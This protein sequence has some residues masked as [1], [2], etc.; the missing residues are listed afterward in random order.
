MGLLAT[1]AVGKGGNDSIFQYSAMAKQRAEEVGG[2]KVV[3]ATIGALLKSDGSLATMKTVEDALREVPFHIQAQYAPIGGTSAY[4]EAMIASVLRDKMPHAHIGGVATPGGTGAL[5]NIFFNYLAEGDACLTSSYLWGNY[6]GLLQENKR[7]LETFDM[8]TEDGAFN[9]EACFKSCKDL[10]DR[11]DRLMLVLNTPAHNPTGYSL[12]DAEWDALMVFFR[13]SC[14]D[15]PEKSHI[16]VIDVA[17][18]D[19]SGPQGRN[20]FEKFSDLPKN[21][22][23]AVAASAS[24]GYT[25]YGYRLGL[26]MCLAPTEEARDDFVKANEASARAT[27]SNCSRPAMEAIAYIHAT[28]ERRQAFYDEVEE[29][30]AMLADRAKVFNDEAAQVGLKTCPYRAGFFVYLP[31]KTH[32][33]AVQLVEDLQKDNIFLVPLGEGVRIAICAIDQDKI[34]GLATRCQKAIDDLQIDV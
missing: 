13:A 21:M 23:V 19:Y 6:R 24:K 32:E 7:S 18:L 16:L 22:L 31:T 27:W 10:R 5:H 14:A 3:N 25:L 34:K 30:S 1:H 15:Y 26:S 28:P 33:G 20:F 9:L 8:F 17:Y 2:D 29:I 11:Q 4:I 12:S